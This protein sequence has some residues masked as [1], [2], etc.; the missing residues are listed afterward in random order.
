MRFKELL[1]RIKTDFGTD[2][3]HQL[4]LRLKGGGL[5]EPEHQIIDTWVNDDD[6]RKLLF[7]TYKKTIEFE[8][9]VARADRYEI[10][11][12]LS[13]LKKAFP[14]DYSDIPVKTMHMLLKQLLL[15]HLGQVN[16]ELS[17]KMVFGKRRIMVVAYTVRLAI[18]V[19]AILII[20]QNLKR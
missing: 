14:A 6:F 3:M 5:T 11:K 4:F 19:L 12:V 9:R 8:N 15:A 18:L 16:W 13:D 1:K 7:K 20:I 17:H 2:E 10:Y